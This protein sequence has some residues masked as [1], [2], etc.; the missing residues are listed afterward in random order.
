MNKRT[1]WIACF[2]TIVL[3]L[4]PASSV[5]AA[6]SPASA[7][8]FKI[9][10]TVTVNDVNKVWKISFNTPLLSSSVNSKTIYVTDSK[11]SKFATTVK[12]SDDALS[13]V[14]TPSGPYQSGDDYYLYITNGIMSMGGA[15]LGEQVVVPFTVDSLSGLSLEVDVTDDLK[16]IIPGYSLGALSLVDSE[17]N[18]LAP[19][20]ND[21][22]TGKFTFSIEQSGDY[23]IKYISLVNNMLTTETV[24]L[25][26]ITVPTNGSSSVKKVSLV[27]PT[28]EG[29]NKG[30][31]GSIGGSI[32]P[33]NLNLQSIRPAPVAVNISNSTTTW[34]TTTDSYGNF[35]VNLPTGTYTLVVDGKSSEYKKHSYKLTVSSGQMVTPLETVNV[36]DP[37]N[38]L[39]LQLNSPLTDDGSGVLSGIDAA[40]TVIAGSVNLD[41]VVNI[42]DT[43]PTTPKLLNSVKP[44]KNGN[45]SAKLSSLKGK[46]I[47]IQVIDSSGN[48]YTLDMNSVVS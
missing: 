27:I 6:T 44:D 41:A 35:K 10:P 19:T 29:I 31:S 17:G 40:T 37:I 38:K 20:F 47:E 33:D 32:V 42:Y 43:L 36:E 26:K 30:K 16:Q 39:G 13:A 14:V 3:L 22:S 8:G 28:E 1:W 12:L 18:S 9:W 24:K 21:Y 46:K 15:P 5:L 34:S 11:Q 25:S 2:L 48:T 4:Q 23:F 7:L 45:F